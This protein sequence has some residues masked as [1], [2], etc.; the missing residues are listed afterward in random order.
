[1]GSGDI[2]FTAQHLDDQAETLLLQLFRG[3]GPRGLSAMPEMRRFGPGWMARP[4]L[5]VGRDGLR[6]YAGEK[7]LSWIEDDMNSNLNFDRSF[8]RH[9]ILPDLKGRWPNI[10]GVLTRVSAHQAEAAALLDD[11]AALDL[12]GFELTSPDALSLDGFQ[13]LSVFRRKNLIR[14]WLRKQGMPTPDSRILGHIL[15]D[16]AGSR[17]DAN[18]CISWHGIEI[19]RYGQILHAAKRQRGHDS[20][21]IGPWDLDTAYHTVLGRLQAVRG[22]GPGIKAAA[23]P[24]KK[25]VVSYRRGGERIRPAAGK[26]HRSLKKLLQEKRVPPWYRDRIPLLYLNDDLVAVAGFW[27]EDRYYAGPEED[28]WKITWEGVDK[29]TLK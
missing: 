21:I 9:G 25:L 12:T 8:I 16:V 5:D 6:E 10:S 17:S 11:L 3:S 27:I 24:D 1:M 2:L 28:A 14:Y 13:N 22:N 7:G 15:T 19:R 4:F 29:V 18:P 23:I 26:H 20:S